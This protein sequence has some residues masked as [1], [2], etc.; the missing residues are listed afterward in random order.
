MGFRD[1]EATT[2]ALGSELVKGLIDDGGPTF[3]RRMAAWPHGRMDAFGI[4]EQ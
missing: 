1:E 3:D 2:H 4:V